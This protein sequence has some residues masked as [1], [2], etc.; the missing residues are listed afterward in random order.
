MNPQAHK[1]VEALDKMKAEHG[2][3]GVIAPSHQTPLMAALLVMIAEDMDKQTRRI[4]RLTW[5]LLIL[6]AALLV[7]TIVLYEDAHKQIQRD[8]LKQ[9]S[10]PKQ[11]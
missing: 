8:T 5:G 6:T 7:F 9:D 2:L 1:L 10:S 11:P 3:A 4:I